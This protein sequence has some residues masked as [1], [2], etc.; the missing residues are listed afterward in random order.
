M[1]KLQAPKRCIS[2]TGIDSV[3][4]ELLKQKQGAFAEDKSM[5]S[6]FCCNGRCRS[7]QAKGTDLLHPMYGKNKM[8]EI[9]WKQRVRDSLKRW[10][11]RLEP[12]SG[13]NS[14][15]SPSVVERNSAQEALILGLWEF[16]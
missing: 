7:L 3:A 1:N 14:E 13:C 11:K 6:L 2:H 12:H 16:L 10:R 4:V 9:K 8:A 5:L 15:A